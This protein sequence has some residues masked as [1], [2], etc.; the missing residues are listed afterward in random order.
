[1]AAPRIEATRRIPMKT[2]NR[3]AKF[4]LSLAI[5][6]TGLSLRVA[7]AQPPSPIPPPLHPGIEGPQSLSPLEAL[8]DAFGN[9]PPDA[10]YDYAPILG[11]V[12]LDTL[13][14]E[15]PEAE[16]ADDSGSS[17]GGSTDSD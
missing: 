2:I 3:K 5:L 1:M 14:D 11:E 6:L 4:G 12:D 16:S 8:D 13:G 10:G 7:C 15:D 17:S 9:E